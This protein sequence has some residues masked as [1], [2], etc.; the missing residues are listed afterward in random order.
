MIVRQERLLFGLIETLT[1]KSH[2]KTQ[3]FKPQEAEA[4]DKAIA[5]IESARL[6]L[7]FGESI[8]ANQLNREAA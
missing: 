8:L 6:E 7:E 2:A 5:A 3:N 4:I 1:K